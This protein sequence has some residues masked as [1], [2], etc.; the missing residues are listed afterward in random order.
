MMYFTVQALG[1]LAV[2]YPVSGSFV[3]YSSRFM[4]PSWGF[5]MAWNYVLGWWLVLPLELVAASITIQYWN[6]SVNPCVWVTIFFLLIIFINLFGVRGYAEAEFIMSLIKV[7]A[8]IGFIIL[9]IVLNCGGGPEGGYIGGKY[10]HNPGAFHNGFKGLCSTFIAAAFSFSGTELVG[11]TAAETENP[12]KTLPKATKQVFWRITLF[13]IISLT[14]VGLLVPYNDQRLFGTSS[15]DAHASPFVIAIEN[16]GIRGLPSVFNVVI[17]VG[18]ISVGNSAVFATSRSILSCAEQGFGPKWF[19]YIDRM[20][21][22][23]SGVLLS[24]A[25]GALGYLAATPSQDLV[26]TWLFSFTGLSAVVTWMCIC[27][28]HLRFRHI[29]MLRD[30]G[31]D[32]LVFRAQAGIWGS[33]I[34]SVIAFFVLVVEFWVC[35][36]PLGSGGKADAVTFFQTWLYLPMMVACW[37]G[38]MIW[39]KDYRLYIK[40]RDVDIDTGRGVFDLN[41][42]REEVAEEKEYLAAQPWWFKLYNFWC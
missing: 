23:L 10:W 16:G 1:E 35:L 33:I 9:G 8:I 29:L 40:N 25:G 22:P 20:G 30:R 42:L 12:R 36:F 24:L 15:V 41:L 13:Y 6:T 28:C 17:L 34:G 32:E 2:A 14:L 4:S 19:G 37:I 11:L 39:K 31:P 38:Y 7:L 26:F 3:Q 21:R 5:A 18:V 27:I